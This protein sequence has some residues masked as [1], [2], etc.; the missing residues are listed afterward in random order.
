MYYIMV[1]LMLFALFRKGNNDRTPL[2]TQGFS[3][4]EMLVVLAIIGI[5]SAVAGVSM[6]TKIREYRLN[7]AIRDLITTMQ[8][9]RITAVRNNNETAVIFDGVRGTYSLC[10]AS[11]DGRWST[12]EDNVCTRTVRL[13]SYGSGIG[14]GYGSA[15]SRNAYPYGITYS[16]KRIYFKPTGETGFG[17]VHIKNEAGQVCLVKTT[18]A[19]AIRSQKWDGMNWNEL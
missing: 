18:S 1:W 14:Y 12:A 5:L 3:L 17:K 15:P 8:K 16:S 2:F 11:G 10:I 6:S 9:A 13:D 19:G 7:A 4:M